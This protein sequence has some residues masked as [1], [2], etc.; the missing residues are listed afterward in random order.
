[1]IGTLP[2]YLKFASVRGRPRMGGERPEDAGRYDT[3]LPGF[4]SL[5]PPEPF[6]PKGR[7]IGVFLRPLHNGWDLARRFLGPTLVP[8]IRLDLHHAGLYASRRIGTWSDPPPYVND[9]AFL[10][11]NDRATGISAGLPAGSCHVVRHP[12]DPFFL[13]RRPAGL[14]SRLSGAFGAVPRRVL[15]P[16]PPEATRRTPA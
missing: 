9:Y 13:D 15:F 7:L 5:G 4:Q 16:G 14:G 10:W 2:P 11:E 12:F 1:M 6:P 3:L 8:E